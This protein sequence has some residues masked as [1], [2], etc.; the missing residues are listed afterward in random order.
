MAGKQSYKDL[1]QLWL[2]IDTLALEARATLRFAMAALVLVGALL[3]AVLFLD[4]GS[5][6][7]IVI[8]ASVVGAYMA[9]NIGA[10]DVANNVGPAV[11]ARALTMS[12]ALVIAALCEASGAIIAG[13]DVV[14]TI[15]KGIASSDQFHTP[16]MFVWSMMSALLAAALW[17]N[18]ATFFGAPVSTTHSVVGGVVGAAVSA[19]G[20]GVVD[21]TTMGTI[22]ASWIISPIMGGVVAAL[23]LYGIK[24]AILFQTDRVAAARRWLPPLVGVVTAAFASYLMTKGLKS[25]WQ[26]PVS[27]IAV[28]SLGLGVAAGLSARPLVARASANASNRRKA[29][30]K[31]FAV[32]LIVAAALLSF[33]HGANDVANAV[34]PLAAIVGVIEFGNVPDAM[35]VPTWIM[36]I[37]AVGISAGLLIYGPRVIRTVGQEITRLDEIRAFCVALSAAITVLLASALGLPVSST[38][39]AVG[40]VFGVGF[41]REYLANNK[42]GA[43]AKAPSVKA[44]AKRRLVRRRHIFGIAAA[45]VITVP[46]TALLAAVIFAVISLLR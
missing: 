4:H 10:N 27:L 19:A 12:G 14:Q 30:S 37:G 23:F 13:G 7:L 36:T 2:V 25:I 9:M 34:G 43:A 28:L 24:K 44:L 41:L 5:G 40:G 46:V 29:V 18:L 20:F 39:I 15:S 21:W 3:F 16:M 11:G 8:L 45:W 38:H 1:S 33:A 42:P 22:V 6:Q 31:L 32:P 26:P 17:L 35:A